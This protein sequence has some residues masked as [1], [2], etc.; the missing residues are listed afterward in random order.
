MIRDDD[1]RDDI[2]IFMYNKQNMFI[3][4]FS[5][6]DTNHIVIFLYIIADNGRVDKV[7]ILN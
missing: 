1:D 6:I 7:T 3:F 5:A 2:N 4:K